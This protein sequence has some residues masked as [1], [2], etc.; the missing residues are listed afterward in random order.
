MVACG[1]VRFAADIRAGAAGD[2]GIFTAF[3]LDADI[4]ALLREEASEALK[5]Q[6][7][8]A[9]NMSTFGEQGVDTSLK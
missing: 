2:R 7:G 3:A 6:L 5:G 8:F 4:P 1:E 9:R